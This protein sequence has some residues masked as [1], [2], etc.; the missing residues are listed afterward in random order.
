MHLL[1]FVS[2]VPYNDII[3]ANKSRELRL[4]CLLPLSTI[5]QLYHGGQFYWW[6]KLEYTEK[7]TDLPQVTNKSKKFISTHVKICTQLTE[8]SKYAG[9]NHFVLSWQSLKVIPITELIL[10]L[11]FFY[12]M[13]VFDLSQL[14][15]A[16]SRCNPHY[17]TNKIWL[18]QQRVE[19]SGHRS[20]HLVS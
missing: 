9:K 3:L 19:W 20:Q 14:S 7:T 13:H 17:V 4:L 5:F 18:M 1:Y 10:H 16:A 2:C 12:K 6:R 8:N 11:H 15:L